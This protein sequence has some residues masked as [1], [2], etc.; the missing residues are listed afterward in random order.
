MATRVTK[1]N[2]TTITVETTIE[3]GGPMLKA[4]EG[5]L[6]AVNEWGRQRR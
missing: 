6:A 2:G 1:S 3:I 5:I 4:E